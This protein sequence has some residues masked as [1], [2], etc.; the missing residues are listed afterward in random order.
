MTP[1]SVSPGPGWLRRTGWS[2]SRRSWAERLAGLAL[3]FAAGAVGW[4]RATLPQVVLAALAVAGVAAVAL[5][6]RRGWLRL[7]GPVLFYDL[8]RTARRRRVHLSRVLYALGLLLVLWLVYESTVAPPR[9]RGYRMTVRH[10]AEA[11]DV[12]FAWFMGAQFAAVVV[13]TPGF[14]A[15]AVAE[16]KE[17]R[18]LEFV[19]ATDLRDR[20]IVLGKLAARALNLTLFLLTGLPVFSALQF[21][22]GIDPGLVLAGYAATGLTLAS[23]AA[24]STL[25]S[26]LCRR[27]R[28]AVLATYLV[29]AAYFG[30]TLA[31]FGL[32]RSPWLA[33]VASLSVRLAGKTVS[34]TD[35]VDALGAGNPL[36]GLIELFGRGGG[37]PLADRI[38]GV[39]GGYA[40]FHGLATVGCAALAVR[41]LRPVALRQL[42]GGVGAGSGRRAAARPPVGDP[43][44]VWKEVVFES[45]RPRRRLAGAGLALLVAMSFGPALVMTGDLIVDL[46]RGRAVPAWSAQRKPAED[47][48]EARLRLYAEGMNAWVRGVG[49]AVGTLAL[50]GVA[51]R[52]AASVGGERDRRTL[53]S[54]LTSPLSARELLAGKWLGAFVGGRWAWLWLLL[55]WAAGLASGGLHPLALALLVP[56]WF[57]FAALMT[58]LGLWFSV[59]CRSAQQATVATLAAAFLVCGGHWLLLFLGCV[60]PVNI[61]GGRPGRLDFLFAVWTGLTPPGVFGVLP[62]RSLEPYPY[63]SYRNEFLPGFSLGTALGVALALLAAA[64]LWLETV[65]RFART[66]NRPQT[67]N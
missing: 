11:A 48:V 16:E 52:A 64:V 20:E 45:H 40:A 1:P 51:V 44:M 5:L 57:A 32:A 55:I 34:A 25:A 22:G 4:F 18:T 53:D 24:V 46:V 29:A 17:R 49:A 8:V 58:S 35:A 41:L 61:L 21:V 60:L 39:L 54:L 56:V 10:Q 67:T 3:L 47:A 26:V 63:S 36:V 65:R 30:V 13:L 9:A 31:L 2:N 43:P 33:D 28:E 66:T 27:A 62:F 19:L 59:A 50:F 6:F 15:G 42:F 37:T 38:G 23:L 7:F 14:V 12:F